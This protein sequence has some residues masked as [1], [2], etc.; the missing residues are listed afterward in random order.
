MTAPRYESEPD[1]QVTWRF[2]DEKN[3]FIA[4]YSL[5]N[6]EMGK[7]SGY[8]VDCGYPKLLVQRTIDSVIS[9]TRSLEYKKRVDEKSFHVPFKIRC[10]SGAKEL[11]SHINGRNDSSLREAHVFSSMEVPVLKTAFTRGATLASLLFE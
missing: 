4:N 8:F 6:S 11:Q 7:L 1:I 9:K 2:R 3:L 10:G 5:I